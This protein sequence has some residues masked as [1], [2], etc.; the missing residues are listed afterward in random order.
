MVKLATGRRR[1]AVSAALVLALGL[2]VMSPSVADD[3]S[4]L[5]E[6]KREVT[7]KIEDAQES[8][9]ESSKA[10][11]A[12]AKKLAA[13]Q[14]VLDKAQKRLDTTRAQLAEAQRRDA[15]MQRKLEQTQ[16][17]LEAAE[18]RLKRSEK[19]LAKAE[20]GIQQFAIET[21]QQGDPSLRAVSGL[22]QGKST[23]E[24]SEQMSI[25]SS[26]ADAQAAELQRLDARKV[27]LQIERDAVEKL[28]DQ[29]K[30]QREEAAANLVRMRELEADAEV[31]AT[32]VAGLVADRE[33]ARK[34]AAKIKSADA[35]KLAA[36]ESERSRVQ[37]R[38][39]AIVA[40]EL[41]EARRRARANKGSNGDGGGGRDSSDSGSSR[42]MHPVSGP[43]T[44]RYGMRLHPVTGVYK[45]HDGT[46]FGVGCGT[47]IR[48]AASGTIIEQYYNAGYG[49]RVI[50]NHGVMRGK[51][52]ITTY[53]HLSGY[54]RST[55][56]RVDRG[57]VIGYVGSTGYST[58]CHL[59]FMVLVNGSTTNPMNWL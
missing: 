18:K 53:N 5:K 39:R 22:L 25:N 45:L 32:K 7:G 44:S 31:Q 27:M 8:Y 42:L 48:A 10:Y 56:A 33:V 43:I 1:T 19:E 14:A 9:D 24:F 40:R 46:D 17:K 37:A 51:S 23:S 54:R 38:L 15:E 35:A 4:D 3:K 47:P 55:G 57:D 52:V 6:R 20:V 36:L 28:R 49:N 29:V 21:L 13:A 30:A 11:A 34:A 26:I 59:H 2:G 41:A 58:G 12:A 50:I 16:A